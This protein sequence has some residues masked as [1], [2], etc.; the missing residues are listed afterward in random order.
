MLVSD[1]GLAAYTGTD[2]MAVEVRSLA[3]GKPVAGVA[4]RLYA[5]NNGELASVTS[6]ADGHRAHPRRVCCTA[7]AATSH[8]P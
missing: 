6:D 4:V 2:G 1:L 5:R 7:A 8:L 3:G